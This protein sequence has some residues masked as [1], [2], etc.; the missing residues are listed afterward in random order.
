MRSC[1]LSLPMS[2]LGGFWR[3][4]REFSSSSLSDSRLL[5]NW[6]TISSRM[7]SDERNESAAQTQLQVRPRSGDGGRTCARQKRHANLE[8]IGKILVRQV[9]CRYPLCEDGTLP[10]VKATN[11]LHDSIPKKGKTEGFFLA[12]HAPT[13]GELTAPKCDLVECRLDVIQ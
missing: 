3:I 5:S 2:S 12:R 4:G 13:R 9:R 8:A 1:S 7:K 6:G 11:K 10:L